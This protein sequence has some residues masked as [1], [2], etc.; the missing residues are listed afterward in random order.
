MVCPSQKISSP[1][2]G[3]PTFRT[4]SA[5][6]VF[7]ALYPGQQSQSARANNYSCTAHR[8]RSCPR[9][10][11]AR[12]LVQ[13]ESG[14]PLSQP[15]HGRWSWWWWWLMDQNHGCP[16][17]AS[18]HDIDLLHIASGRTAAASSTYICA[19]SGAMRGY[20][21]WVYSS[22]LKNRHCASILY[23]LLFYLLQH[24]RL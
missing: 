19:E 22:R 4:W 11:A 24:A 12:S 13:F 5:K 17:G 10:P 2:L 8:W 7:F 15:G 20:V 23:C 21:A 6:G 18:Q 1:C 14:A 3:A 16:Q 9:R